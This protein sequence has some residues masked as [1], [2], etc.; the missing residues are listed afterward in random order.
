MKVLS[1]HPYNRSRCQDTIAFLKMAQ[2]S[3][4][5]SEFRTALT[6]WLAEA[7]ALIEDEAYAAAKFY[8]SR[9]RTRRSAINAYERFLDAYPQ[10]THADEVRARIAELK[11]EGK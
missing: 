7:N 4:P 6:A 10:S 2:L 1:D 11:G 8:D 3:G 5:D 9:T